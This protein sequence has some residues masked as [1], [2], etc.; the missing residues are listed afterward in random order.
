MNFWDMKTGTARM[1]DKGPTSEVPVLSLSPDG[2]S[3]IAWAK[4]QLEFYDIAKAKQVE[5]QTVSPGDVG[6]LTL[7]ADGALAALAVK[8]SG[9]V[10][11]WDVV[12]KKPLANG[13]FPAHQEAIQD[14]MLTP[15]KKTLVTTDKKGNVKTWDL[16]KLGAGAGKPAKPPEP[17]KTWQ[18]HKAPVSAL[19][20]SLDGK[21]FATGGQDNV[22]KIWETATGKE[23]RTFDLQ[24][25]RPSCIHNM[26]YTP[27]NKHVVT[28]NHDTT[29][30]LLD[31]P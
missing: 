26:A 10:A 2:K 6:A 1:A 19:A 28:A 9:N 29:S 18:A 23:L 8:M 4:S 25:N 31:L 14:L 3:I 12:A 22:I 24:V 17:V 16:T 30:Y 5:T 7:S 20:M 27:D 11:L 13:E 15:D 21:T